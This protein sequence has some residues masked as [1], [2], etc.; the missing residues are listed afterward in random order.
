MSKFVGL[1][2]KF[3]FSTLVI[4][5]KSLKIC[6]F[7]TPSLSEVSSFMDDPIATPC[8]VKSILKIN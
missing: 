2:K 4:P 8:I 7:V 3:K 5:Y 1:R 6:I